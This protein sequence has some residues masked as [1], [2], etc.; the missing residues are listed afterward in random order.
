MAKTTRLSGPEQVAD[1]IKRTD[2]PLKPVLEVLRELILRSNKEITE[3]IKWNAPSFCFG[4]DDRI[5]FNLSKKDCLLLIFH[6]G[7]KGKEVKDK[8]PSLKDSTGLLEWLSSERA[9]VKLYNVEEVNEKKT[10][11]TKVVKQRIKEA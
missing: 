4:G 10:K 9:V 1:F 3:H 8:E 2:Y 6:R 5:T 11:L 7:A